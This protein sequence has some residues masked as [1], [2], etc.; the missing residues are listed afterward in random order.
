MKLAGHTIG[1]PEYT[2]PEAIDLF[3]RLGL[4]GIEAI[5]HDEYRSAIR[6]DI[7]PAGLRELRQRSEDRGVRFA[8]ITPYAT[9][10][11]SPDPGVAAVN[12]DLIL[13][14][15]DIA[16]AVGAPTVRTYAGKE[17]GEPGRAERLRRLVEVVRGPAEIAAK[18]GVRLGFE[19]H[20]NTLAD[21]AK[22]SVEVVRAVGHPGVGI[23]YDQGNL[24]MLGA[25]DYRETVPL[26]APY[27][28]HVHVKDIS[29]KDKPPETTSDRVDRLPA[30]ARPT[31]SRILGEGVLPWREI[32]REL[33]RTGYDGYLSMEY[34][35]RWYP[36]QL[37][38][39]EI[40]MR[41]GAELVRQILKDLAGR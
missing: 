7:T 16:H 36:E 24:T 20:F 2:V 35:R 19:N 41:T 1:S 8:A 17:T 40:G 5:C 6:P 29:F 32:L 33:K 15:I 28:V 13:R 14:A 23:V 34:E 18:A 30:E 21:S 25:E 12:R 39:A 37:P 9:D 4:E 31:V 10:L 27:V 3:G 11:N 22:A 38:P 26:Q